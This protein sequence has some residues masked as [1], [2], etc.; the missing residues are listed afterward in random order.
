[1]KNNKTFEILSKL[2]KKDWRELA[3]M[4]E[5]PFFNRR[6]EVSGLLDYLSECIVDKGEIPTKEAAFKRLFPLKP[7][8]DHRIRMT[9]S[10][11]NQLMEQ[12]LV[13][14]H[15]SNDARAFNFALSKEMRR[16]KIKKGFDAAIA[17]TDRLFAAYPYRNAD[18]LE[19]YYQMRL[20]QYR[21]EVDLGQ[22]AGLNLQHLSV[23]LDNAYLARKLWQSCFMLSHEAVTSISYDFG[24]LSPVLAAIAQQPALLDTPAV[25]V[26]YYCYQA[27]V[28]PDETT[29]F[30]EFRR[31]MEQ[32]E[33]LF[34]ADDRR[35]MFVLAVNFC[36]RQY[37]AGKQTYL[38]DQF[39]LYQKGLEMGY[40][41]TDGQLSK[42]TYLNV[43]TI[44]MVLREYD[45]VTGFIETYRS[46]LAPEHCDS[47]YSFNLARLAYQQNDYN[48]AIRLLQ[49][50]DYKDLPLSL[51]AKTLQ[52]KIF[53]ALGETDLLDS[54]LQAIRIFIRRKKI[55]GYTRENY[56]N[57]VRFVQKI[58]EINPLDKSARQMLLHEIEATKA[59]AE[60]E[61]L[62]GLL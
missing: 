2:E 61:W 53:Y 8:D 23:H 16:M 27:L 15:F 25:A 37:N 26:Y 62:L 40:F 59:V 36:I 1:M 11:L 9:I 58:L 13:I 33:A 7:F 45:W 50:A 12:Y 17:D 47:L 57:T 18:Y 49:K 24:L 35:D 55:L 31:L 22:V 41:V 48:T 5:S 20:E 6:P 4:A 21:I 60:K 56:L 34:P 42:Y 3:R 32:D 39:D 29:Y 38:Q 43:A 14:R 51:A 44:G 54:H 28:M 19:Q 10:F 46:W 30:Q 52:I